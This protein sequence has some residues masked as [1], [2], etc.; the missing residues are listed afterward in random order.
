MAPFEALYGRKC[1]TPLCW[2][3]SRENVMLGPEIVQQTTEK[4]K[5]IRVKMRASQ[6]RQKSYAD[7]RRKDV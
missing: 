7:K 3:E 1:R 5:M 2:F 6:S 4:I